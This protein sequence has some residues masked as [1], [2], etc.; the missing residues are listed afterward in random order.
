MS[1]TAVRNR[2]RIRYP[3]KSAIRW[4][5]G[6]FPDAIGKV[7]AHHPVD[8]RLLVKNQHTHRE[9]WIATHRIVEVRT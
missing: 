9:Y 5:N 3:N 2:F 6:N 7:V 4:T 1:P 8:D